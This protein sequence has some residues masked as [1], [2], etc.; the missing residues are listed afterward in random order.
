MNWEEYIYDENKPP[1]T[2]GGKWSSG[3]LIS[4]FH[5]FLFAL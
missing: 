4:E 1:E 5:L 3:V 2:L